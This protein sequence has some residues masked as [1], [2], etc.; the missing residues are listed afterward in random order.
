M[1]EG[2]WQLSKGGMPASP[3]DPCPDQQ[4][5]LAPSYPTPHCRCHSEPALQPAP[6]VEAAHVA[7]AWARPSHEA[8]PPAMASGAAWVAAHNSHEHR[9]HSSVEASAQQHAHQ[10]LGCQAPQCVSRPCGDGRALGRNLAQTEGSSPRGLAGR[11]LGTG[12]ALGADGVSRSLG[13]RD[14]VSS[15]MEGPTSSGTLE[16]GCSTCPDLAG[17]H[18]ETVPQSGRFSSALVAS[19]SGAHGTQDAGPKLSR[20]G[21]RCR[22][23][24]VAQGESSR[25]ELGPCGSGALREPTPSTPATAAMSPSCSQPSA[26][27]EAG[28]RVKR[29]RKSGVEKME[30]V[31]GVGHEK[32]ATAP[33][34]S[35]A[36]VR[37]SRTGS[38]ESQGSSSTGPAGDQSEPRRGAFEG[39]VAAVSARLSE[40]EPRRGHGS[41]GAR[42]SRGRE[43]ETSPLR[44]FLAGPGLAWPHRLREPSH[45]PQPPGVRSLK[46]SPST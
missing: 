34:D 6:P 1:Q 43:F 18:G 13:A 5:G 35:L 29:N 10:G 33:T 26:V 22:E 36:A 41:R 30:G 27:Q 25:I 31:R 9:G 44:S 39:T 37:Q 21:K 24:S 4:A 17:V 11:D 3:A 16:D 40:E 28:N 42:R 7:A 2:A 23:N 12:G 15:T 45:M 46:P 8:P 20:Y 38:A 32:M 14:G 19:G